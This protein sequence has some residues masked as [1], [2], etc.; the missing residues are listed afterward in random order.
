MGMDAEK[1]SVQEIKRG[2]KPTD[3]EGNSINWE[4]K[5]E[6]NAFDNNGILKGEEKSLFPCNERV[7]LPTF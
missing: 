4:K 7:E 2:K 5:E 3:G 6:E 1:D